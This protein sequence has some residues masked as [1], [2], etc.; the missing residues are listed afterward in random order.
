M[1]KVQNN[2]CTSHLQRVLNLIHSALAL[3]LNSVI[4]LEFPS[5]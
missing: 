4:T 1:E 5:T 2:S 3:T